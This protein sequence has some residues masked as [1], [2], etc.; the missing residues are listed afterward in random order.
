MFTS[1]SSQE[2]QL[3]FALGGKNKRVFSLQ[4][5]IDTLNISPQHARTLASKMVKKQ[6]A[7]RVKPGLFVRIPESIILDKHL[8]KE[9]AVL[10]AVKSF[11]NAFLSH[12]TALSFYGLAER[13]STQIYV[14]IPQHKRDIFYHE[15]L[16]KF[17]HVIP[18][19]FFGINTIEYSNEK[20]QI[21]DLERTILDIINRPNYAGGWSEI[22]AC[23]KNLE[24]INWKNL[25][26]YMKR[27]ENK[28]LTRRIGYIFDSLDTIPFPETIKNEI[29]KYSG[30][31]IYYFDPTRKGVLHH[32][33]NIVVPIAITE[34]FHA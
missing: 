1:M 3:Y 17:V 22:I 24:Q 10:I 7:E 11:H 23:L 2:Q 16:I 4:D 34:A 20:I 31:N 26:K 21:S 29:K 12:Y 9:D 33:W 8:Y 13:Y 30:N 28:V 5:I 19:R 6:V 14:T 25:I 27:F 18:Q 15:I 32:E